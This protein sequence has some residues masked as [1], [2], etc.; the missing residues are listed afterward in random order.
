MVKV[1]ES[2][3]LLENAENIDSFSFIEAI[4]DDFPEINIYR[5]RWWMLVVFS[6][7]A[8]IT[9]SFA[10]TWVVLAETENAV[11]G[12]ESEE[13]AMTSAGTAAGYILA[14]FPMMYLIETKGMTILQNLIYIIGRNACT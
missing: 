3:P 11:Y 10:V 6:F 8:F 1:R 14:A 2:A 13:I 7:S 4:Q 9:G 12:W 5:R